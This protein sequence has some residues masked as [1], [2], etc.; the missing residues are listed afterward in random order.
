MPVWAVG[1]LLF[2]SRS[3]HTHARPRWVSSV[4]LPDLLELIKRRLLSL[5]LVVSERSKKV[6]T[7][8]SSE[9][10]ASQPLFLLR[11]Q[12]PGISR[13]SLSIQPSALITRA[14][15]EWRRRYCSRAVVSVACR[16]TIPPGFLNKQPPFNVRVEFMAAA[17]FYFGAA[18][19]AE[20]NLRCDFLIFFWRKDWANGRRGWFIV[21]LLLLSSSAEKN[22]CAL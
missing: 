22:L 20:W 18:V 14:Q 1:G 17:G 6:A 12:P 10:G 2:S 9:L 13:C 11:D 3:T 15:D 21:G 5:S 4:C 8:P 16:G 19:R 7:R